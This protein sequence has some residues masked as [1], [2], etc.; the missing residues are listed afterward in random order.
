MDSTGWRPG[1]V[2][3]R[4]QG[5]K[6]QRRKTLT[7]RGYYASLLNVLGGSGCRVVAAA[8]FPMAGGRKS[9]PAS[10]VKNE[11]QQVAEK[12]QIVMLSEA[13]HP[14]ISLKINAEILRRAQDD[15]RMNPFQQ[16]GKNKPSGETN[17]M[18]VSY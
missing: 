15:R 9:D 16:P 14:C 6:Q 3:P 1:T 8:A 10:G 11:L 2:R 13:R 18:A 12:G 17:N 7:N 5:L 4:F